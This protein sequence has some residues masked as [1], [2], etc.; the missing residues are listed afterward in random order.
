MCC[1][2]FIFC[3]QGS[4]ASDRHWHKGAAKQRGNECVST[5]NGRTQVCESIRGYQ[6]KL[7]LHP[8]PGQ[9]PF[10]SRVVIEPISLASVRVTKVIDHMFVSDVVEFL[11]EIRS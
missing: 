10:E 7:P 6:P 8:H 1:C 9:H 5:C 4:G 11:E 3:S 2:W